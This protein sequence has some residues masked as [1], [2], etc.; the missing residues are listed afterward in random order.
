MRRELAIMDL[1][2]T[3]VLVELVFAVEVALVADIIRMTASCRL[4]RENITRREQMT[5]STW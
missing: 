5:L 1:V 3:Q 2:S 4:P